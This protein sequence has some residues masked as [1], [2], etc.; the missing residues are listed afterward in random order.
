MRVSGILA[1][2][3]SLG[4][5]TT[6]IG[7][8]PQP[9]TPG[10]TVQPGQ[11]TPGQPTR[12]P[13]RPLRPGETPPKG[14]A[15][16]RGYVTAA[17]SGT[18]VR[19]VQ[20][21]ARAMDA[22]GG[23]GVTSTDSEGRFEIKELPAG[24]Y[25]LF[26][27]KGGF[28]S[29]NYGQKRP[30]EQGTPIELV[31]AQTVE[32][33]NFALSRGAVIAGRI[34]DDGGEPVS[35][36]QVTAVRYAFMGGS[37]RLMPA[38]SEGSNDRTDDQG[39]FRLFGLPPGDYYVSAVN[40][41]NGM[42]MM[43]GNNTEAEGFAPT[44][45][46]GT[47]NIGEATRISL[48]AGQEM[49]GANFAMII[50]RMARVRGRAMNS[51]GEP[52]PRM[53]LTL[54]PGDPSQMS[55]MMNMNNAMVRPDGGFEFANVPPGRYNIQAR[56]MGMP[57]AN[58]EFAIVPITVGNDDIDSVMVTTSMGA[59]AHGVI[60][61]DDGQAP[62]FLPSAVQVSANTVEPMMMMGGMPQT[63]VNDDF[64]FS[65]GGLSERRLLRAFVP[66]G[67]YV[68][69]VYHGSDEVTDSGVDFVPGRDVEGLQIV[70]TR[71]AT[72][73]SGLVTDDR[74]RPVV[75]ASVVIF[76]ANRERWTTQSRYLRTLR[77][78]TQGRYTTKGLPPGEDYLIIAVA[79]LEQGQGGD[80]EFLDRAKE[81]AK[82]LTLNEGEV[83]AM[84]IKL[85]TLRP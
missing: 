8:T 72:D 61:T 35:G 69:A 84:D 13:A 7:Q 75:D 82:P 6:V 70:M 68:K 18:P 11:P 65:I 66:G 47:P 48:K 60:V 26:A 83:K 28:V 46:P 16:I 77:P 54:T 34:L 22:N 31:D 25:M 23:G 57:D 32:K 2:A 45:Y 5:A 20:V 3:L 56:P 29:S 51:K 40:R 62:T 4:A 52:V 50:A 71:K 44:Y 78:D 38:P 33:L 21:S 41:G 80:P 73:L 79:N 24:R 49:A 17:G 10:Q 19:R 64:S 39:G 30:G 9:T 55:M 43:V 42:V 1:F 27:Q 37:R 59:T 58:S 12:M 81:E 67:W 76:P 53:M 14:T 74:N 36:T 85:S 63:K 15:V